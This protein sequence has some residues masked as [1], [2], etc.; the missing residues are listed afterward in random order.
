ME[1]R[2]GGRELLWITQTLLFSHL[3]RKGTKGREGEL[4]TQRRKRKKE[5]V[6][7]LGK[8]FFFPLTFQ[9]VGL[10]YFFVLSL[11]DNIE[12]CISRSSVACLSGAR[13]LMKSGLTQYQLSI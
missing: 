2:G 8:H 7:D 13:V 11:F 3:R 6:P 1:R 12:K 4:Q 9:I 5:A 10:P